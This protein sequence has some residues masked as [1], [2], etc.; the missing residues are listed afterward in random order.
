MVTDT[1]LSKPIAEAERADF[2]QG[3]RSQTDKLDFLFQ[4]LVKTSRLETG[5]I[6]LEKKDSLLFDTLAMA[7]SEIVYDAGK[8]IFPHRW[9]APKI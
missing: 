8:R 5:T 4:A 7:C 2:L 6:R 3:I 1:L 9:T